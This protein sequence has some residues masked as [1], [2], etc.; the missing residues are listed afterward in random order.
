MPPAGEWELSGDEMVE[1]PSMGCVRTLIA[2]WEGGDARRIEVRVDADSQTSS[3]PIAKTSL[4]AQET[5][6]PLK[7]VASGVAGVEANLGVNA[8]QVGKKKTRKLECGCTRC[9]ARSEHFRSELNRA[10]GVKCERCGSN[11]VEVR[12][13]SVD[14]APLGQ[15]ATCASAMPSRMSDSG[16]RDRERSHHELQ[17]FDGARSAST[18]EHVSDLADRLGP[19]WL[20][21]DDA[22]GKQP[23]P[24]TAPGSEGGGSFFSF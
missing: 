15:P 2:A 6:G 12:Y 23:E 11:V 17:R 13:V 19:P 3:A 16:K 14:V 9:G 21:A 8:M 5:D 7:E 10:G 18:F 4:R 1:G 22:S 24:Q 20:D